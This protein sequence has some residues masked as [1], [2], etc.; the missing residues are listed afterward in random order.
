MLEV[1]WWCPECGT[2]QNEAALEEMV[3]KARDILAEALKLRSVCV[4]VTL[5]CFWCVTYDTKYVL[6]PS[7]EAISR[8]KNS[9]K[10]S[11][12]CQLYVTAFI[13]VLYSIVIP[14]GLYYSK[15]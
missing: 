10:A 12:V 7:L 2:R 1:F 4:C 13:Y 3:Q 11:L 15:L 6:H 9:W 5:P 8:R 14:H